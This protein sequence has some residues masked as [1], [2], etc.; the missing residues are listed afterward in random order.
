[1]KIG[2]LGCGVISNTYIADIQKFF[3]DIDIKGCADIDKKKA[4]ETAEK[5][6]I[7]NAYTVEEI[8]SDEEIEIIVNLTPPFLHTE[9]NRKILAAGKHLYCEKPFALTLKD[10][11][12]ICQMAKENH[13]QIGGAPETFLGSAM[14]TCRKLIDD[15]W[16][17][18][19]LYATANM[20]NH[21]VETW[22]P[23]PIAYYKKGGGPL[24]DMGP[25]YLSALVSLLGGIDNLYAYG[26]TGFDKRMIYSEPLNGQEVT[27]DVTTH[28][29]VALKMKS[30][31]IVNMNLSFDI[32]HSSL[33]MLEIYGTE[34]TLVVPD[35]NMYGGTPKVFRREQILDKMFTDEERP[36]D[37]TNIVPMEVPELYHHIKDYSRG[38]GVLDL[39]KAVETEKYARTGPELI[40]HITEAMEGIEQSVHTGEKYVMTTEC[41]KPE[42]IQTGLP[43]GKI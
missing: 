36:I 15:G 8:L 32:W 11:E 43:V 18:K 17:G 13:L 30:D 35:P 21:G 4:Q 40:C 38:I 27:V 41:M 14:Q 2:I 12:E 10:A 9:V 25:Y 29:T 31:V 33:P 39:V 24:F 6:N 34:G 22:H 3:K 26:G 23:A 20:V 42:P 28:Y 37:E 1:M 19:P 7:P 5:Y 16:I